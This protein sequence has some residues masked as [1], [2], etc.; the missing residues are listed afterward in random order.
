MRVTDRHVFFF[1]SLA[2]RRLGKDVLFIHPTVTTYNSDITPVH[3]CISI[4]PFLMNSLAH[5]QHLLYFY[6]N[7]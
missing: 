4:H 1:S 6:I 5:M 2:D 7:I 3:C